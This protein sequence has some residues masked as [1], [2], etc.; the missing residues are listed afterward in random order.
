LLVSQQSLNFRILGLYSRIQ[1]LNL[2][3]EDG[4]SGLTNPGNPLH[5][6]PIFLI[7]L[8]PKPEYLVIDLQL[9]IGILLPERIVQLAQPLNLLILVRAEFFEAGC[10]RLFEAFLGSDEFLELGDLGLE[11]LV[12]VEVLGF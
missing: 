3:H 6:R 10:V 11:L 2:L 8:I 5:P 1:G 12:G 7:E 9:Q 4:L